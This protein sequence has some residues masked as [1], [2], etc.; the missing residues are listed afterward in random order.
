MSLTSILDR[1][2]DRILHTEVK[3]QMAFQEMLGSGAKA[4]DNG[5]EAFR[6]SMAPVVKPLNP[7]LDSI[8]NIILMTQ[9]RFKG[10]LHSVETLRESLLEAPLAQHIRADNAHQ[11]DEMLD[12][13][14][15]K[16]L[17][18]KSL[19]ADGYDEMIHKTSSMGLASL[20]GIGIKTFKDSPQVAAAAVAATAS[21]GYFSGAGDVFTN[22]GS[23]T[24]YI[25][26]LALQ[27]TPLQMSATQ[28]T[29]IFAGI[30]LAGLCA[31]WS[32]LKAKFPAL[33]HEKRDEWNERLNRWRDYLNLPVGRILAKTISFAQDA[34]YYP[35]DPLT[36][37]TKALLRGGALATG[38]KGIDKEQLE[39]I[40]AVQK[41]LTG[42]FGMPGPKA[43][44]AAT[45][46]LGQEATDANEL[47]SL[48]K[49]RQI[50][51]EWI[52][53]YDFDKTRCVTLPSVQ[54]EEYAHNSMPSP[55]L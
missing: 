22:L 8:D 17:A 21:V 28:G 51:A 15:L 55:G 29:V 13:F 19:G 11:I 36:P 44:F 38:M 46:L 20:I 39:T 23:G 41:I 35:T 45:E 14:H 43:A 9:L 1:L 18:R 53:R 48:L 47:I 26:N 31:A 33:V 16:R 27:G 54:E 37:E 6:L 4:L 34:L 12:S 52:A 50:P 25:A 5:I 7:I 42:P 10:S 40:D 2:D 49:T 3:L 30:S 24:A 32:I